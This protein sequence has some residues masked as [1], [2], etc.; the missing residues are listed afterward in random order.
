MSNLCVPVAARG[1]A[2]EVNVFASHV[3]HKEE[4]NW[5]ITNQKG[6]KCEI[7]AFFSEK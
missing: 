2:M 3:M 4:L 6:I 1:T 5:D 7:S